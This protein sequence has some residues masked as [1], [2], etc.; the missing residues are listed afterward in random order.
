MDERFHNKS[1]TSYQ[2]IPETAAIENNMEIIVLKHLLK[3]VL[4]ATI[5]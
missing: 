4:C 3:E 5:D 1:Y 2:L